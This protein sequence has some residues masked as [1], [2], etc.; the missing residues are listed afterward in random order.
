MENLEFTNYGLEEL[1]SGDLQEIE[2]GL[3]VSVI[4]GIIVGLMIA[5]RIKNR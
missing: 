1:S 3:V 4:A 5:W 2:G